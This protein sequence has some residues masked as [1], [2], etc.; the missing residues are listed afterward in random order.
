MQAHWGAMFSIRGYS[1]ACE[2]ILNRYQVLLTKNWNVLMVW[3]LNKSVCDSTC[4]KESYNQKVILTQ[5][6]NPFPPPWPR[7]STTP[8][9]ISR[10][11]WHF[12]LKSGINCSPS[13]RGFFPA[14]ISKRWRTFFS[15]VSR[16]SWGWPA[17]RPISYLQKSTNASQPVVLIVSASV[18]V[19][20]EKILIFWYDKSALCKQNY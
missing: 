18:P 15:L 13:D 5:M 6:I 10:T 8:R 2:S 9:I 1:L 16:V 4:L 3:S 11:S 7:F 12:K 14:R 17:W 20:V 19:V